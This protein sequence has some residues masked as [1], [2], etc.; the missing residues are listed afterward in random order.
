MNVATTISTDIVLARANYIETYNSGDLNALERLYTPT[1]IRKNPGW[2]DAI[3]SSEIKA[4]FADHFS[5]FGNQH[6]A[7]SHLFVDDN[8][9]VTI[10]T[11]HGTQ[12]AE[13]FEVPTS[14]A[15]VGVMGCSVLWFDN[16]GRIEKECTY[17]DPYGVMKQ[18]GA[19]A[20]PGRE[21][22]E[23]SDKPEIYIAQ[24]SS[25]ETTNLQHLRTYHDY[26]LTG[27]LEPWLDYM[28]DDI[29]WDDQMAP[30]LAI[31]KEHST[32]DFH[33]LLNAFGDPR[34][35]PINVWGN[36]Q[37]VIHQGVFV[38]K[39]KGDLKGIPASNRTVVVDNI[40]VISF[41]NGKI[42]KGWTFGNSIDMGYQLGYGQDA[43]E[44]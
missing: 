17:W 7:D 24:N 12:D 15:T 20:E 1:A 36:N 10:W 11:W 42:N 3:G 25:Q 41:E 18:L 38:A 32:S 40:D 30:G 8:R 2:P 9:I 34:I 44:E 6:I 35:V 26:L 43:V 21:L 31:G 27:Q 4:V 16:S 13:F 22:P 39:H 14:N 19:G 23:H 37:F 5:T 29:A 28:T 33:M